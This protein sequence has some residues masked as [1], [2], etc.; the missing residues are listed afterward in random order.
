MRKLHHPYTLATVIVFLAGTLL[1]PAL[2]QGAPL[3][4]TLFT[5]YYFFSSYQDLGWVV[6]GSTAESSG[7]Y[8]SGIL[9]PFGKIGVLIEGN[10]STNLTTGTVT[11]YIYVVDVASGSGGNGVVLYVYKKKDTI[12]SSS[13]TV[14]VT[15]TKAVTLP[16]TGGST[17]ACSM[18]ANNSFL[19]IGTDQD[20]QAVMVKK[21]NLSVSQVG[22]YIIGPG[23]TR[24]TANKYGYI[25]VTQ[26]TFGTGTNGFTVFDP[27]GAP[28][29]DGGGAE[30]MLNTMTGFSTA[31]LP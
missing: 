9:G 4:G 24:I 19:F 18:A 12:T 28:K 31:A 26:G 2:A 11:R 22:L 10:P 17:V 5:S 23:V 3:D 29:E 1:L 21:S 27:T 30:F 7:C 16:L 14:T 25:T 15:L 20:Q 8:A 6:C 13:D